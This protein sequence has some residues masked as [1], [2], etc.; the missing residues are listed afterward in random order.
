MADG[1]PGALRAGDLMGTWEL[2]RW[3]LEADDGA[4]ERPFGPRP[5]GIV[6]YTA[7]GHMVTTIG[8]PDRAVAGRDLL[9][10]D[11]AAR[12][13]AVATF[14]AYSGTYVVEGDDVVHTVAMSLDPAWVGTHQRR[15]ARL[16]DEGRTLTLST[17]PLLVA[18]RRGRHRL[19]WERVAG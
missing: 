6:V 19:T 13:S 11:D 14:I 12:R 10:V 16:S 5:Q 18:G 15:H 4:V 9:S 17:D 2:R 8:H 3:E 7:D 1:G